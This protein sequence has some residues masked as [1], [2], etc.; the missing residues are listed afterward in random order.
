[1][2]SV[3]FCW[4]LQE[5]VIRAPYFLYNVTYRFPVYH[6]EGFCEFDKYNVEVHILFN[7]FLRYLSQ[8][9]NLRCSLLCT[10]STLHLWEWRQTLSLVWWKSISCRICRN[11]FYF[12]SWRGY[13]QSILPVYRDFQMFQNVS[14]TGMK[15]LY[16]ALTHS[17][18]NFLMLSDCARRFS[19]S[20]NRINLTHSLR[21]HTSSDGLTFVQ[22]G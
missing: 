15:Y 12:T 9:D 3:L 10:E 1:M 17:F 19:V 13:Y 18:N 6:T 7:A 21:I 11:H 16:K 20:E 5:Y 8:E 14:Y 22:C 4:V 2:P